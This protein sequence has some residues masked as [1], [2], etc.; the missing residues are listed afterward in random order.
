MIRLYSQDEKLLAVFA[1]DGSNKCPYFDDELYEELNGVSELVFSV[2]MDHP[3]AEHVVEE[4]LVVI[5]DPDEPGIYRLFSIKR[6]EDIRVEDGKLYKRV[7][8]EEQAISELNDEIVTDRRPQNATAYE[9]LKAALESDG[10]SRWQVG[11]VDATNN[12]STNF[13]YESRMSALQKILETWGVEVRFR[14]QLASTGISGRFVDLFIQRGEDNGIR[15]EV[16]R[17]LKSIKRTVE[18]DNIKTALYGRG[19]GEQVEETGGYGRRLTFADVEWST[20]NQEPPDPV[21]KPAGQEWVGDPEAL[22]R[23]GYINPDGT[24]RHRFGVYVNE[25]QEDPKALLQETWDELQRLKEPRITY[26]ISMF[27]LGQLAGYPH[28]RAKLGDVV[29][30]VDKGFN[31]PLA[32]EARVIKRRRPLGND[33][34]TELTLGNFKP[35]ITDLIREIRQDVDKKVEVGAP[36]SWLETV[37][38]T[39]A[40]EMDNLP[41][42]MTYSPGR[43]LLV[44]N[45]PDLESATSAIEIRGG[46]FRISNK[47]IKK[48]DGTVDF[49]WRTFGDGNGFTADELV[50]GTLN[51]SLVQIKSYISDTVGSREVTISNGYVSSYF[52][53]VLTVQMGEWA[54]WYYP[55][56]SSGEPLDKDLAGLVYGSVRLTDRNDIGLVLA[57]KDYVI[58]GRDAKTTTETH[59]SVNFMNGQSFFFGPA[60]SV[61][62]DLRQMWI[63]PDVKYLQEGMSRGQPSIYF[64]R[65][66]TPEGVYT[67]DVRIRVGD[68]KNPTA[69]G[70]FSVYRNIDT[71]SQRLLEISNEAFHFGLDN[72]SSQTIYIGTYA[73]INTSGDVA[74]WQASNNDYIYQSRADG[75]IAFYMG[76]TIKHQFNPDGTKIGGSIEIDGKTWGMSPIDSPRILLSD[77]IAD[78]QVDEKGVTV[79]LDDRLAASLASYTV[80]PNR[81]DVTISEKTPNSFKVTGPAGTVDLLIIGVRI[82][83]EHIYFE[84]LDQA[85]ESNEPGVSAQSASILGE[86]SASDEDNDPIDKDESQILT[87]PELKRRWEAK[88]RNGKN[89]R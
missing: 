6:L 7:E 29:R 67:A 78:Q 81:S 38:E 12:A 71:G 8:C 4:N 43:G 68:A 44:A 52:D 76:G 75:T 63:G 37:M 9:A 2:P 85:N 55:Y 16:G 69:G 47:P 66:T 60:H 39:K 30:V 49:E 34:E 13:Y 53:E 36:I 59:F 58:I 22:E 64:T 79:T 48:P 27:D 18:T 1:N 33:R 14:V 73:R 21:D 26:E 41:G 10:G 57:G 80:F 74:R 35:E 50:A 62:E 65:G 54:T 83:K 20:M 45:A 89:T 3:D 5:E 17:N 51:A 77:L 46:G 70:V 28:Y 87:P 88:Q 42:F 24:K 11:M 25:E 31:P 56:D 23:W 15:V 40:R 82:G 19:K 72:T 61:K 32:V 84:D 86:V